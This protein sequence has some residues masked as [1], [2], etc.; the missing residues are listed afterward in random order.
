MADDDV[1]ALLTGAG[2]HSRGLRGGIGLLCEE[3]AGPGE[4]VMATGLTRRGAEA[5]LRAVGTDADGAEGRVRIRADR[6]ATYRALAEPARTSADEGAALE[7]M[8]G[9]V[10]QAPAPLRVL[11][12]VAATPRTVL[13]RAKFLLEHYDLPGHAVLCLG[14]HDL[15]SLG[16]RLAGSDGVAVR[17]VDLD[18]RVLHHID[19]Q[20][21]D[22]DC[23]HADL[24]LGLPA[25][26]VSSSDVVITDPPY[27]PEGVRLFLSRAVQALRDTGAGRILLA[28]GFGDQPALGLA[29][30]DAIHGLHLV[31]EAALPGF[32]RYDGA[33]AIGATATLYVLRPTTRSLPA[34]R[35][36]R[37]ATRVYTHGE[38]AVEATALALSS[39]DLAAVLDLLAAEG[40]VLLVGDGFGPDLPG[41]R[42][43][44]ARLLASP[45]PAARALPTAVDLAPAYGASLAR[46]LLA[47]AAPRV[48]LLCHN[49]TS[50]LSSAAGQAELRAMVAPTYDIN[51]ILRSTPRPDLA[52]VLA[53]RRPDDGGVLR[54]VYDRPHGR[55]ANT[56]PDALAGEQEVSRAA[57]REVVAR[58]APA[59][60]GHTLLDLPS[61][62]LAAL[63][64][65]VERSVS[66]L[67]AR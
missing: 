18:D 61:H 13:D 6:V 29:V 62:R 10:A 57:A 20:Q 30:Q 44:L 49:G 60:G 36:R 2:I 25:G 3:F 67:P 37:G 1:R 50:S 66:V 33:H 64:A 65:A 55:L 16:L 41:R 24:R 40:D 48:V 42:V 22:I 23:F 5:L 21:L 39:A 14:D 35:D 31:I 56:W 54:Q 59:L 51:R 28:Y 26:L 7:R 46:V 32:N 43:P 17:V 34:A 8:R 52:L 45:L 63:P 11:D 47:C 12:H 27:T 58:L 19:A 53:T 15:T 9:L 38:Q 4:L